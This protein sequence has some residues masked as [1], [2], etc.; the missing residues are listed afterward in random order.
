M[1]IAQLFL[2]TFRWGKGFGLIGRF[3]GD[4]H[5]LNQRNVIYGVAFYCFLMVLGN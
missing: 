3:L 1:Q 5:W 4:D 2:S